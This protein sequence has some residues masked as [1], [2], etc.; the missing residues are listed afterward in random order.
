M[1]K[2]STYEKQKTPFLASCFETGKATIK[3]INPGKDD[4]VKIS[5]GFTIVST[6]ISHNITAKFVWLHK[7]KCHD[8][9]SWQICTL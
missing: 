8:Q 6:D 7:K 3:Q 2:C 1:N 9:V 5:G 4:C